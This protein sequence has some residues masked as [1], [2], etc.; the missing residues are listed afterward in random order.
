[1][2]FH[3]E[4]D[5][6]GFPVVA[7]LGQEGG[8]Q[9]EEGMFIGEDAGHAGAA[10]E[11]LVDANGSP[12]S[13]SGQVGKDLRQPASSFLKSCL[14]RPSRTGPVVSFVSVISVLIRMRS[15]PVRGGDPFSHPS[16]SSVTRPARVTVQTAVRE[17][18]STHGAR[19]PPGIPGARKHSVPSRVHSVETN[20]GS[21]RLAAARPTWR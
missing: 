12:I 18:A 21:R 1:M 19:P 17:L 9:A 2:V 11:F 14:F 20:G 13:V 10:F 6:S 15:L 4:V 8:D 7:G 5:C 3:A 16:G